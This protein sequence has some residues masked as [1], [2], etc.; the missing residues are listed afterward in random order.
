MTAAGSEP[1]GATTKPDEGAE[2][3]VEDAIE[4]F[5]EDLDE[6]GE[7]RTRLPDPSRDTDGDGV[8]DDDL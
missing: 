3:A 7:Q 4:Y 5:S 2:G 8:D 6:E 1:V